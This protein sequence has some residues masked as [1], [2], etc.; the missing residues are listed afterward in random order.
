M[1][2]DFREVARLT[3]ESLR[4]EGDKACHPA[5]RTTLL[6]NRLTGLHYNY[7]AHCHNL[8][9]YPSFL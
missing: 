9:N 6:I 2:E 3:K 4:G 7:S 5:M 8:G 1:E